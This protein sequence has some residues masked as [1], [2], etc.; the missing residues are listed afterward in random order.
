[1]AGSSFEVSLSQLADTQL[2]QDAP[3]LMDHKVGFQL[4]DKNDDDTRGVGVMVFK[5]GKQ[6]IYVPVFYLNGR[7]KGTD[8]MYL[9]QQHIFVPCKENWISFTQDSSVNSLAEVAMQDEKLIA[10]KGRPGTVSLI[11]P[12]TRIIKTASSRVNS[13]I[14]TDTIAGMF[15]HPDYRNPIDLRKIIPRMGK[16]AAAQLLYIMN[17]STDVANALLEHY[18]LADLTAMA[19]QA[20]ENDKD[21]TVTEEVTVKIITKDSPDAKKLNDKAKSELLRD[22]LYIIDNRKDTAVVFKDSPRSSLNTPKRSGRYSILMSDGTY[23][24]FDVLVIKSIATKSTTKTAFNPDTLY[25][26]KP[27]ADTA[28]RVASKD[29]LATVSDP[30]SSFSTKGKPIS[31]LKEEITNID[32]FIIF[33]HKGNA[34]KCNAK[35]NSKFI[36]NTL[37]VI[38]NDFLEGTLVFTEHDGVLYRAGG[39]IFVPRTARY[40]KLKVD[41][42]SVGSTSAIL[43]SIKG[44]IDI[45]PLKLYSDGINIV[46]S[47]NNYDSGPLSK[48][49]AIRELVLKYNVSGDTAKFMV[50]EASSKVGPHTERY[51][52]KDANLTPVQIE[53]TAAQSSPLEIT[54]E[55]IGGRVSNDDIAAIEAAARSGQKEVIDVSVLKT[56]ALRSSALEQVEEYLPD[57]IRGMDRVGRLLFLFYWQNDTFRERYGSSEMVDLEASLRDVFKN[58]SDLIL[59][60]YKKS[61]SPVSVLDATSGELSYNLGI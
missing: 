45:Q 44:S 60:L 1:M 27:G 24:E 11:G 37:E 59:F 55:V 14:D 32:G 9:Q 53:S 29:I 20:A 10:E 17:K 21:N 43:A 18:S 56:L 57:L 42:V 52:I 2:S 7:I 34:I 40:V 26:F 47:G 54:E 61:V 25:I 31:K 12:E 39:T 38:Y 46:I 6:W 15:S 30:N 49:A 48:S 22:G 28:N 58:L 36:G 3:S 33:D 41:S 23:E 8:L 5:L 4:I 35:A 13:L 51:L 50:K 19:K 16:E